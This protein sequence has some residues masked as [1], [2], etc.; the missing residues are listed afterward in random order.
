MLILTALTLGPSLGMIH[1]RPLRGC[2]V[3]VITRG[4]GA[5]NAEE[6][7]ALTTLSAWI[8]PACVGVWA[9]SN[10]GCWTPR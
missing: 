2:Q 8:S 4:E 10:Y 6:F 7:G 3:P 9:T 5:E 1:L